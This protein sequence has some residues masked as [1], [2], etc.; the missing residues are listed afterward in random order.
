MIP[1]G[2]GKEIRIDCGIVGAYPSVTW[3][4]KKPG[5]IS[6]LILPNDTD[7]HQPTIGQLLILGVEARNEG[8]Y[9]C[10]GG[11]MNRMGNILHN[12]T[13]LGMNFV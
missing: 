11:T 9:H 4:F 13:V 10:N 1:G 6:M 8:L 3:S 5:H 12:I 7:Y 2:Q